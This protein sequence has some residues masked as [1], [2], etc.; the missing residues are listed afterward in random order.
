MSEARAIFDEQ[1]KRRPTFDPDSVPIELSGVVVYFPK[2]RITIRRTHGSNGKSGGEALRSFGPDYDKLTEAL[3]EAGGDG[4]SVH[5]FAVALFD[6]AADLI[7][8]NYD[9][10]EDELDSLL[11]FDVAEWSR[12]DTGL[13]EPWNQIWEVARGIGP[14][15]KDVG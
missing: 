5:D 8:R 3:I 7:R 14:K 12:S 10:T 9:V 15:V 6:L 2:P 11:S 13:P 1:A 4:K